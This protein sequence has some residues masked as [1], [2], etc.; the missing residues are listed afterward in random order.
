[1]YAQPVLV[2]TTAPNGL[3]EERIPAVLSYSLGWFSGVIALFF[4][5]QNRFI[6]FHALQSIFFFGAVNVFDFVSFRLLFSG[7]HHIPLWTI[8]TLI[9]LMVVNAIAAIGWILGMVQ[10]GSG[11]YHQFPLIGNAIMRR[12]VAPI[13]TK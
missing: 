1:M 7:L 10:A 5:W 8:S 13:P 2:Y 12:F 9:I 4:G 11:K 3:S 6:R